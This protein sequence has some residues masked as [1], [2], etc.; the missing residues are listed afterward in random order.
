MWT[1]KERNFGTMPDTGFHWSLKRGQTSIKGTAVESS[2]PRVIR[3]A[4]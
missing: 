2:A 1:V 3:T 4:S